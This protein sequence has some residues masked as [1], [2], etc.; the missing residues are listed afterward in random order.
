[1]AGELLAGA[2][3]GLAGMNGARGR[4]VRLVVWLEGWVDVFHGPGEDVQILWWRGECPVDEGIEFALGRATALGP[5]PDPEAFE[6]DGVLF[7]EVLR[8]LPRVFHGFVP[9]CS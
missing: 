3:L 9:V 5:V 4:T 7:Y 1:M 2:G 8:R 6:G